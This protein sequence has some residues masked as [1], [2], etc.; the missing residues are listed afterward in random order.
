MGP[1]QITLRRDRSG[2]GILDW[3]RA[4]EAAHAPH[5]KLILLVHGFNVSEEEAAASYQKFREHFKAQGAHILAGQ[6]GEVYWPGDEENKIISTISFPLK[7]PRA[8]AVSASFAEYLSARRSPL[9][10]PSQILLIGH[11]L[12]CR[13]IL[14]TLNLLVDQKR[15]SPDIR[16]FLM[17][18]GVPIQMVEPKGRLRQAVEFASHAYTFYS[19]K[20][21]ALRVFP[22]G[23][24]LAEGGNRRQNE[25]V[26]RNGK[27]ESGLWTDRYWMEGFDHGHYWSKPDV[28]SLILRKLRKPAPRPI[29]NRIIKMI[30]DPQLRPAKFRREIIARKSPSRN[31]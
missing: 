8:V 5:S 31:I 1:I 19:D 7:V 6:L 21:K 28:A 14:E 2:G 29:A 17:A 4:T 24:H 20:D 23:Q 25:A 26:G 27:P 30:Q 3:H 13:V 22:L 12:G 18:A 11:S 16:I 10:Q 9:R 15:R